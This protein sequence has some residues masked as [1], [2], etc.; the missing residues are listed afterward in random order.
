[1][2]RTSFAYLLAVALFPVGNHA[3]GQSANEQPP[4][5]CDEPAISL[6]TAPIKTRADLA[7]YLADT[8]TSNPLM[9]LSEEARRRLLDT[10]VVNKNGEISSFRT[11]DIRS[12]LSPADARRVFSLFGLPELA[13]K[14]DCHE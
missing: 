1:M 9:G 6:E 2:R 4:K 13:P 5:P 7:R 3:F 14:V 12:E 10:V 8:D 11:D